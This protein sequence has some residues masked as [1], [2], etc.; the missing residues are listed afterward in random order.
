MIIN[1]I[2]HSIHEMSLLTISTHVERS[3]KKT[4]REEKVLM[5]KLETS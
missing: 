1:F 5:S 3:E 4:K 2:S